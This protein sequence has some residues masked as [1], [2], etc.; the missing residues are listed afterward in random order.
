MAHA[1]L[2]PA[3]FAEGCSAFPSRYRGLGTS[4]MLA[5][6]D[7]G[8]LLGAPTAGLIVHYSLAWGLPGYPTMFI[9]VA[10]VLGVATV[11]YIVAPRR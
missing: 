4:L 6:Y 1:V 10:I 2:F 8:Q 7:V 5:T 9:S 11:V 3:G